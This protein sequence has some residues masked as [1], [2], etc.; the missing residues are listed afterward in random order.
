[1]R[2]KFELYHVLG[3]FLLLRLPCEFSID[4]GL[5]SLLIG[6]LTVINLSLMW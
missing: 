4:S 3:P 5:L 2:T 1:M 6:L